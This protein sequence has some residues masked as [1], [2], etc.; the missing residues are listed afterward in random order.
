MTPTP[1]AA[2]LLETVE[3]ETGPS[4]EWTV[5]WLHGLGADGND[6]APIVPE[7][8]RPQWPSVRFVFPHAP[9]RAVTIN[10]GVR[11]RAWYDIRDFNLASRADMDGVNESVTQIDALIERERERGIPAER[12]ILGGFSQGGAVTLA[13]ALRRETPLAGFVALSTY[14]PS[15]PVAAD[16]PEAA[17]RQPAFVGHGT[18]DPVVPFRAG[19]HSSSVLREMGFEVEWHAY[20][21]AHQVCP[22][23]LAH[24]AAWFSQ[25]FKS[26]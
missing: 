21:M 4:P 5:L 2:T 25:R 15:T 8:T 14:L 19:Q 18:H 20:A 17:R 1:T 7:L 3:R 16:V 11:M 13:A 12:V 10:N 23:E 6:F 9:V 26:R 24:L 22:D